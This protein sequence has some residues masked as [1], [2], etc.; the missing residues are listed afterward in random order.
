MAT[1]RVVSR[2]Q[3]LFRQGDE[4]DAIYL[5]QSGSLEISLMSDDGRKLALNI[6]KRGDIFGEVG[7]IDGG[8]RSATATALEDCSLLRV[9]RRRLLDEFTKTP[10]LALELMGL[11]IERVRWIG[12]QLEDHALQP[13]EIR[14]A[15]RIVFLAE[16]LS[17]DKGRIPLSQSD[18]ADHVSATREAVSKKLSEWKHLGVVEV[19]RGNFE[20][21]DY[22]ALKIIA[23]IDQV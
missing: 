19:R 6:L 5:L 16:R 15:R 11:L 8:R 3:D 17:D 18:L 7:L 20:I 13:L 14:L 4:G 21:L 22:Q 2:G 10:T 1:I 23:A 9:G 12:S